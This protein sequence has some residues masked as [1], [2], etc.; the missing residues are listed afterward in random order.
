MEL[1]SCIRWV[2]WRSKFILPTLQYEW[3]R[4]HFNRSLMYFLLKLNG[5]A[6]RISRSRVV[7]DSLSSWWKGIY[8]AENKWFVVV[9]EI[10][11]AQYLVAGVSVIRDIEIAKCGPPLL[12]S[13]LSKWRGF[14]LPPHL[15]ILFST[16]F[17]G[18]SLTF[19][20]LILCYVSKLA[21]KINS[22][23]SG[24]VSHM[25]VFDKVY[26]ANRVQPK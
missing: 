10:T 19:A 16:L 20:G 15:I 21:I 2:K 22:H 13:I 7:N 18:F 8:L 17:G 4:K 24:Q 9:C 6:L 26:P 25:S 11:Q 14:S 3:L 5:N 1:T 12:R 23:S